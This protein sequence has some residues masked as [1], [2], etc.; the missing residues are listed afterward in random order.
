MNPSQVDIET[1]AARVLRLESSNRRWKSASAIALLLVVS[2]LLLSTRHTERVAAA[3]RADRIEPDVLH[4]RAVE[5]QAFVLK[6][7]DGQVYARLGLS[8]LVDVKKRGGMYLLPSDG[9]SAGQAALQ[10]YNEKGDV[11][12][13]APSEAHL[14]PVKP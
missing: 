9:P 10:F 12:W 7:P 11:V 14:L 1:L 4:V 3:A 8:P 5:A 6:D 13:T 2:L